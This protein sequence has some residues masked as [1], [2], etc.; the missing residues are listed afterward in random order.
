[1]KTLKFKHSLATQGYLLPQNPQAIPGHFGNTIT[2][3]VTDVPPHE[4]H[5]TVAK[6]LDD[7][8]MP[9]GMYSIK[10]DQLGLNLYRAENS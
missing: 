6:K 8:L 9:P 4:S 3:E 7:T 2:I 10:Y 5:A 1:M